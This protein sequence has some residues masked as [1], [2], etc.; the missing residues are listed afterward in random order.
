MERELGNGGWS[1]TPEEAAGWV[2]RGAAGEIVLN[3]KERMFCML[4]ILSSFLSYKRFSFFI[5]VDLCSIQESS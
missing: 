5:H 3:E 1:R 4:P 2:C